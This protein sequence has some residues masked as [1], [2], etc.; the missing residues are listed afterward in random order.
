MIPKQEILQM[1]T[2]TNLSAQVIEKDYVLGWIL[3]GINRNEALKNSWVFKGGTCLKKCYFDTYRFSEDLDFTLKDASHFD[4]NFLEN[5]FSEISEW[6][7]DQSGIELPV[8]RMIFDRYKPGSC[9]GRIYY[10]GPITPTSPKQMP[11][12]KLDLTVQ[13]LIS[14]P[15]VF[16]LV[17]HTYSDLPEDKIY[18]QC[19]AYIEV[20]AEKIRALAERTRPRDLYDVI[21][22]FRRPESKNLAAEVRRVL[23]KKCEFKNIPIPTYDNLFLHMEV[24]HSGWEQQLA[25]Q[26]QALP[27]FELFWDELQAFFNWLENHEIIIQP[28][29]N[30]PTRENTTH[31]TGISNLWH[32]GSDTPKLSILEKIRFA[33]ANHLCVKIQYTREDGQSKTYIIE[34]Y[35]LR[36][37]TEGYLLIYALKNQTKDIR[38][39]RTDRIMEVKVTS[40]SFIPSYH[41]EFLPSGPLNTTLPVSSPG[42]VSLGLPRKITKNSS[43]N[44]QKK[45]QGIKYVYQC[46][47]CNK[48]FSKSRMLSTLNQH[49]NK[50]GYKCSGRTGIYRGN[51]IRIV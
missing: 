6:L 21:N 15:P 30:I 48:K 19:Y 9:Q 5:A 3:A 11:R 18:I 13:E 35:S 4:N 43:S 29:P 49:K 47:I 37:S 32:Y 31:D 26:L 33:A 44:W 22:F 10:R 7:Y 1:A 12:V 46:P 34:P 8:D 23:Q 20:F 16:N 17:N 25:H 24:C 45:V 28:L 42:Q 50:Q 38:S 41:I 2:D 39:F 51:K 40:E 36:K 27:P 14:E